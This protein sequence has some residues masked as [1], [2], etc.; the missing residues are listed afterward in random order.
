[1]KRPAVT[2]R[3][4]PLH[5]G[6]VSAVALAFGLVLALAGPVSANPAL[7]KFEWPRTDFTKTSVDFDSIMSGGPPKDGIP[8]IDAPRFVPLSDYRSDAE[9]EP[10]IAF[11][12]GGYARAYPLRVLIWHEIVNDTVAGVPVAV[13][14]CPLCNSAVVF[15][16]RVGGRV[17]EFGTTGKLRKSDMV[18]YDR[19]TESWWQQF[20]GTGI[21]G[22]MTG[23]ELKMLPARVESI[24]RFRARHP[25]GRVLVP[26]DP[27]LRPYGSNPYRG[28]DTAAQP[29]LYRG[30]MPEGI[31]PLAYVVKVGDRAWSL[32]L[33]KEKG[34]IEAGDLVLTWAAGRNS[35]L[36]RQKIAE[37]RD[38][39]NVTVQRRTPHGLRDEVH[40][41]TFA[42]VF[43]AF[44]EN[45][46]LHK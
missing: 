4:D 26:T 43:H 22:E 30:E 3:A 36:D 20:T 45:G 10:V 18:M 37:G 15:D 28:Y 40:D 1:M 11:E 21:V 8:S 9:T 31:A 35:A 46:T 38:I 14:Y 27:D 16:R 12:Q 23:A 13:T 39:G 6:I 7:W 42:F 41:V 44:V 19:Q 25:H 32:D 5:A 24:A 17:L 2:A 34:R 33:L 29:F